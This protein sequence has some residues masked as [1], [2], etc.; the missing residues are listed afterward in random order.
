MATRLCDV[1]LSRSP[2]FR[3]PQG[4]TGARDENFSPSSARI[5]GGNCTTQRRRVRQVTRSF[6]PS[7]PELSRVWTA[8][9]FTV[10]TKTGR[11]RRRRTRPG[12][13][14]PGCASRPRVLRDCMSSERSRGCTPGKFCPVDP[15]CEPPP[16]H[17]LVLTCLT[18]TALIPGPRLPLPRGFWLEY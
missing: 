17:P 5:L 18:K 15:P 13:F 1:R 14:S 6:S 11:H 7:P 12:N 4:H 16:P 10:N 3:I 2:L 8:R 9:E